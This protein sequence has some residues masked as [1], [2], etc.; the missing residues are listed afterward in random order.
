MKKLSALSACLLLCLLLT[1][2]ALAA[3]VPQSFLCENLNGQQRIVKTYVLS[4]SADADELIEAP[5]DFEGY[6]YSWAYTTMKER[7]YT[8]TKT[9]TETVTVETAK[10]D[11]S[12]ILAELAPTLPFDDG[13]FSGELAL[14]HT[15]IQTEAAGY[16]TR[17]STV[18]ETK[19]I[20]SLPSNDMSY[21]PATTL[22][23]GKTLNLASV[24]WQ[25]SA[26][27]L[28]GEELVPSQY[29]AVATYT[30]SG[31]YQ[32]AT[33]YVTTAEYKGTVTAEGIEDITYTVVFTGEEIAP[34]VEE[35]ALLRSVAA[36]KPTLLPMCAIAL[37]LVIAGT[38]IWL[39]ARRKNVYV[40]V[41][42]DKPRDYK[43]VAKYRLR[44][45][46]EP[47]I[48]L[49]GLAL[50]SEESVA[51]EIKRRLAKHIKGQIMTVKCPDGE[52][53]Y[54]VQCDQRD[55]WHE[56]NLTTKTEVMS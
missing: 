37:L 35:R 15:T 45:D 1:V 55:D 33:G 12:L 3:A 25:V 50:G 8:L 30:G 17:R 27:A 41:P 10:N 39:L 52:Y 48:D 5:F 4:P 31:S 44:K 23:N 14:D 56:F 21:I 13:E 20:S 34:V 40:Y 16:E 19:V 11:L 22:K 49:T 53:Q 29:Q 46:D 26:T 2:Q 18:S 9:L 47:V 36:E 42:S 51:I 38:A 54:A 7:P 24:D 32:A 43:L 28:V 6:H